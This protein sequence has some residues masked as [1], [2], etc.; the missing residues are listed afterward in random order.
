MKHSI[1]RLL[2]ASN[3]DGQI[4]LIHLLNLTRFG[5]LANESSKFGTEKIIS[6]LEL[7]LTPIIIVVGI[8]GNALS[9]AVF[10]LTHLRQIS[11]SLFLTTLSV[12]DILFLS[13]LAFVWLEKV[14]V[15]LY[16]SHGW[17]PAVMYVSRVSGCVAA[18]SVVSFTAERYVTVHYPLLKDVICTRKRA[19]CGAVF[20]LSASF[21]FYTYIAWSY[22]VIPMRGLAKSLCS[23]VARHPYF[24]SVMIGADTLLSCLIPTVVIVILNASIIC[25]IRKYQQ[26]NRGASVCYCSK[27]SGHPFATFAQNYCRGNVAGTYEGELRIRFGG[28]TRLRD[29]MSENIGFHRTAEP[30][31]NKQNRL[32]C[33]P[34]V[35]P[36]RDCRN[37]NK[38]FSGSPFEH[39]QTYNQFHRSIVFKS[40]HLRCYHSAR[41]FSYHGVEGDFGD[42]CQ[43]HFSR[44]FR[45]TSSEFQ[46][47]NISNRYDE[48]NPSKP[49]KSIVSSGCFDI[50]EEILAQSP[51][52]DGSCFSKFRNGKIKKNVP[53]PVETDPYKKCRGSRTVGN[54]RKISSPTQRNTISTPGRHIACPRTLPDREIKETPG[55]L[56]NT[57][58]QSALRSVPGCA[59]SPGDDRLRKA[60]KNRNQYRTAKMLL[61][62][63]SLTVLLNLPTYAFR[64]QSVICDLIGSCRHFYQLSRLSQLI[65]FLNFAINFF[66]YNACA[67]QF[68]VELRRLC[69]KTRLKF[70]KFFLLVHKR[71]KNYWNEKTIFE[72]PRCFCN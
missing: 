6:I 15:L 29:Y 53:I 46:R 41:H 42:A 1:D 36:L 69:S 20:M 37:F 61:T 45:Q 70:V 40:S 50:G 39:E 8:L 43:R 34:G 51:E 19:S 27:P 25:K 11:S 24:M 2:N 57:K 55:K 22:Q 17:C 21:I 58:K 63:S 67:R 60:L 35:Y 10:S 44:H 18:W 30:Q 4:I 14:D 3:P 54:I 5:G 33:S 38:P 32:K 62:L 31:T 47:M 65:Y 66:V 26:Q 59:R 13:S 23:P 28:Q 72:Q 48:G 56:K 9:L 71:L 49:R 7:Y 68:R 12:A 52:K 16:T 64:V